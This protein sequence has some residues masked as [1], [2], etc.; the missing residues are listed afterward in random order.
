MAVFLGVDIGTS[1]AKCLAV[2]A[3]GTVLAFAQSA[4]PIRH[5]HEGWSEQDPEDYVQGLAAVVGRCIAELGGKG[6]SAADIRALALSTQADTLIVCDDAGRP[7]RPA[8]TWM[9]TRA[10]NEHDELLAEHGAS[11]WYAQLGQPLSPYS[12]VGKL[13]WLR[14]HEP[15]LM[16]RTPH[17]AYVPDY[18]AR[19]L[20][21]RWVTDVPSASW[22]PFLTPTDRSRAQAV[23]GVLDIAAAQVSQAIES[24][25]V[26]GELLADMA[27]ELGLHRGTKLVAGAFDQSAA[28]RGAG[29]MAGGTSVLSCGTAWVVYSVARSAPIDTSGRLCICC[30]TCPD[31]WGIVLPFTGG[32]AY[33]W[34]TRNVTPDTHASASSP[35]IFVPHLYGGLSP[36]WQGESRGSLLGLTLSH[37]A[38]DIRL[39]L[40]RGMAFETRRNMEAA[41]PHSGG[42][43][44]LRMVGGATHSDIWPQMIA[45]ALGCRVEV[46]EVAEA[47]CYG[48]AM[49]A[50]GDDA[51]GWAPPAPGRVCE[52]DREGAAAMED[53]Y[54]AYCD[55]YA[56][57]VRH[58][59]GE[60]TENREVSA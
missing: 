40:M 37:T 6:R 50:A 2:D 38:E 49:L 25:G 15:G 26:I 18:L 23:L 33:D 24:T 14:R 34:V 3:D 48:A 52:P 20:T 27:D 56:W 7:L 16:A 55:A 35:L 59:T 39:A 19:R 22:S 41:A 53:L 36:D 30:H 12:S 46:A 32:S 43:A 45:D 58:Y 29:A 10:Q 21:G 13:R 44:T 31:E 9:D 51:E 57:L 8:M 5:P 17:I 11:F 28:A 42:P 54:R 47:G 60:R 1:S 4:V